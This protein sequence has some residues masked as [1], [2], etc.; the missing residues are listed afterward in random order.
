MIV[1][2]SS[3]W[4]DY[5]QGVQNWQTIWLDRSL[6]RRIALID[7]IL[8]EVL[9]GIKTETQFQATHSKLRKFSILSTG[10]EEL[11]IAAA[12]NYR[13]LRSRGVTV[14][15][16]IDCLIATICITEGH[17]LL[18]SDR[19]FDGFEKHLGLSVVHPVTH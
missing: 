18:H 17:T 11:A 4:I 15:T 12:K 16:T 1:V 6:N 7:V 5:F 14:R 2:D 9:Q 10:G 13:T 3:V 8:C 19:D